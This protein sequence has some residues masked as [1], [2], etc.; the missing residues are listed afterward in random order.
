[1]QELSNV[2]APRARG[3][4][5]VVRELD[6][7]TLIYDLEHNRAHCLNRTAGLVW[8][9]CNGDTT[10]GE[11]AELLQ[12]QLGVDADDQTVWHALL[13]LQKDSLLE[14]AVSRPIPTGMSRREL[15]QRAGVVV[16]AAAVT[17]IAVPSAYAAGGSPLSVCLSTSV[18]SS[19]K[20]PLN[21]NGQNNGMCVACAD[22]SGIL[23]CNNSINCCG[24]NSPNSS[25]VC[26][27]NLSCCKPDSNGRSVC[28]K[29]LH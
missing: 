6:D 22:N 13:Q 26:C 7:E 15:I 17:S 8:R 10:I 12:A 9:H 27:A 5:L 20:N 24:A 1:M 25:S 18:G 29:C 19:C 2:L 11:L 4:G 28:T 23:C 16:A 14:E 3:N 21:G